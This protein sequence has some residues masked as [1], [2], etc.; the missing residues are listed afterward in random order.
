M[1]RID[2]ARGVAAGALGAWAGPAAAQ[3]SDL[4]TIRL[5]TNVNDD[6]TPLFWAQASGIFTRAGL[7][8]DIVKFTSGSTAIAAPA[9]THG[10]SR[11][12]VR[13]IQPLIDA[14]LR[15]GVIKTPITA[16]SMIAPGVA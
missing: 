9:V 4:T 10:A 8:V 3:T 2:F 5:G 11:L 6:S 1:K 16:K 13:E 15:Y 14:A 12:D 7:K